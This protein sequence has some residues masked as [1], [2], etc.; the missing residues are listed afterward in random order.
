MVRFMDLEI[1]RDRR[2]WRR[3]GSRNVVMLNVDV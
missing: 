3:Q 1:V 2:A